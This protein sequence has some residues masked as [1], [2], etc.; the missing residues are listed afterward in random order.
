M[1]ASGRSI[2]VL[3]FAALSVVILGY[4]FSLS[5]IS[6]MSFRMFFSFAVLSTL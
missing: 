3:F 2:F 1:C 6:Q 4:Q 5:I